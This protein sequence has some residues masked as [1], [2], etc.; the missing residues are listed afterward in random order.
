MGGFLGGIVG[1]LIQRGLDPGIQ[2]KS[3]TDRRI[4]EQYQTLVKDLRLAGLNPALAY[5]SANASTSATGTAVQ[6]RLQSGFNLEGALSDATSAYTKGDK[7]NEEQQALRAQANLAKEGSAKTKAEAELTRLA[8]P[9]AQAKSLIWTQIADGI[10][11]LNDQ[12]LNFKSMWKS[13][14]GAIGTP[15]TSSQKHGPPTQ[16]IK[17]N[18]GA[19]RTRRPTK[20]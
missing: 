18:A 7:L 20:P 8:Q 5:G 14:Q 2:G 11:E 16:T 1:P 12:G 15:Q 9:E 19:K 3:A 10:K 17:R 13:L 6:G 4:R